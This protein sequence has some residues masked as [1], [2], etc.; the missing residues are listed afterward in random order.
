MSPRYRTDTGIT[1][2]G[3]SA[4]APGALA[5]ALALAPALV[6][7][8]SGADRAMAEGRIPERVVG[9]LDSISA[10]ARVALGPARLVHLPDQDDTDFDKAL[11][12]VE[13]P[14]LLA[15]GFTGARLDHTLAGM[16][17]ILR[18]PDVRL[19]VD[20]GIDLCFLAP[21]ELRMTLPPGT[22]LSLYP[23]RPLA[24][25]SAGLLWPT[26]G[27]VLDPG[28]R[29]GTS[30][31]VSEGPVLLRPAAPALLVLTPAETLEAVIAA[32]VAAPRWNG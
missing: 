11:R 4:V 27:L 12:V 24:C 25:D 3:G 23:M 19:V 20:S 18:N 10:A 6:A 2:L 1:L 17:T 31:V 30:N 9:D 8:D 29:I 28:G 32:L 15:L 22:R 14:F 26:G 21:A 13:A 5:R 7:V 16:S